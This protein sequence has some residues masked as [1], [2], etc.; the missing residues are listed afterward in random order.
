[1]KRND[2][3]FLLSL[4]TR[5]VGWN[6]SEDDYYV[7][8][9]KI[10]NFIREHNYA[11]VEELMA[12]LRLGQKNLTWQIIEALA[13]SDPHFYRDYVVFRRFEEFVLPSLREANRGTKK[14]R[15]WSLG[16][17]TGQEAY[18]IAMAIKRKLLNAADW[19]ID[20]VGTDLSSASIA[21]AQK[22]AYS[23]FEVQMGLNAEMIINNFHLERDQWFVND[24]L[25]DM[26]EFRRYNI[27]DEMTL[28]EKFDVIFCRNML[29]FFT[30]QVQY[31]ILD[32]IYKVQTNG[33]FLYLGKD[34]TFDA[35][36][37]FY[38]KVPGFD[39]LYQ[40]K[41]VALNKVV[42]PEEK[43]IE[44]DVDAMPSFVKPASLYEK[45]PVVSE[46]FKK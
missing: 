14:L 7:I 46:F 30:P 11:T 42:L 22:G 5:T 38:D 6:F 19:D 29:R 20:I 25:M 2:F 34:E 43:K 27:L 1:M 3:E 26:V 4:L 28:T 10:S 45:R 37:D 18:S 40:A 17:S 39:C 9:K 8:D 32:K 15:I 23:S 13:M 12:E 41:S 35:V 44:V 33:G 16:C 24:D 21:K 36:A 31:Q